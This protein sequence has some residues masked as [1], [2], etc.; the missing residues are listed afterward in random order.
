MKQLIDAINSFE[1]LDDET[2]K[3]IIKYFVVENLKT[4]KI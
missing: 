1:K 2:E 3:A 4:L